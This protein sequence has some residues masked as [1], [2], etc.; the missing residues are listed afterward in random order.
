MPGK[1]LLELTKEEKE[2]LGFKRIM[3]TR[4]FEKILQYLGHL[5]F[6]SYTIGKFASKNGYEKFR[7]YF[8]GQILVLYKIKGSPAPNLVRKTYEFEF[9]PNTDD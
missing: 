8:N 7:K 3:T 5:Y 4:D 2:K 1:Q 9:V 6:S